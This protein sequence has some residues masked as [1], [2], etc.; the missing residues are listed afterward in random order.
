MLQQIG[1]DI[2]GML[3]DPGDR[4]LSDRPCCIVWDPFDARQ[5]IPW[6]SRSWQTRLGIGS[7]DWVA[8]S[9]FDWAIA[10]L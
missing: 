2:S 3:G 4:A 1:Q 7:I 10:A 8:A 9:R 6:W 5:E